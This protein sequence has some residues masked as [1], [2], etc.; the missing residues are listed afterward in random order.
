VQEEKKLDGV[1]GWLLLLVAMLLLTPLFGMIQTLINNEQLAREYPQISQGESWQRVNVAVWMGHAV[2]SAIRF[3]A[4]YLLVFRKSP[5]TIKWVIGSLWVGGPFLM[6]LGLYIIAGL[7]TGVLHLDPQ[8]TSALSVELL[9]AGTWTI[10]L[11]KSRRVK[12]T[13][14]DTD[15]GS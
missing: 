4:A 11:L 9:L 12:A 7:T 8:V 13:Y 2:S 6:F 14:S 5:V 15:R 1:R 3:F 10:Y